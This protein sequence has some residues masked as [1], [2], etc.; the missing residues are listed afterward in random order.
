MVEPL[1]TFY[2]GSTASNSIDAA[3][4]LYIVNDQDERV[5]GVKRNGIVRRASVNS[6]NFVGSLVNLKKELS[7]KLTLDF[8]VDLR[9][10]RG[11]HYRRLDHLIRC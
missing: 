1:R 3:T 2:N 11:I 10:Y 4:G 8:G 9:S 6:H 5:D 7:D